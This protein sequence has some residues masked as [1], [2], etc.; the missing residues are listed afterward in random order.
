MRLN[1]QRS[2]ADHI[3]LLQNVKKTKRVWI[4]YRVS[5]YNNSKLINQTIY[6]Y[7]PNS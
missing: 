3:L 7:Y 4:E 1:L 5:R 2:V 6:V